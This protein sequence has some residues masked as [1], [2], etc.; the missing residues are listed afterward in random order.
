MVERLT[1]F[2]QE[3]V[4]VLLCFD[5]E[6]SKVIRN[7]VELDLFEGLYKEVATRVYVYI[8][9]F[10]K[11]PGEHISDLFDD[12]INGD[13]RRQ[14]DAYKNFLI[15]LFKSHESIDPHFVMSRL[16]TFVRQQQQ[17]AGIMRAADALQRGAPDADVQVDE[18]FRN[19]LRDRTDLFDAG[20]FL[21]DSRRSF[22]FLNLPDQTLPTGVPELDSRGAGPVKKGLHLFIA[23]TKRGKSWW[24]INLGKHALL[25]HLKVC[26]ITLELSEEQVAQRYFQSLFAMVK[27]GGEEVWNTVLDVDRK[28]RLVDLEQ[29]SHMPKLALDDSDIRSKLQA[30]VDQWGVRFN[31]VLIKEFPTGKLTTRN[32]EAYLDSL[33]AS[34][35]FVPDL[36]IVDYADMMYIDTK[37]YRADVGRVYKDLRGV[38]GERNLAL[39]TASQAHREGEKV[40]L[41]TG[42][43]VA[44]DYSKVGTS[45][46]TIT[47]SQTPDERDLGLARLHVAASRVDVDSYTVLISQSYRTGQFV[48]QSVLLDRLYW[49]LMEEVAEE[50][51]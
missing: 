7:T 13:D 39:A 47:Y 8:D 40:R 42:G 44:E 11:A 5:E 28:G 15:K 10:S 37:N 26:H 3:N 50:G 12:I 38:A 19:V 17:K 27:R 6:N 24:L 51:Q 30:K 34:H 25:R 29:I 46:T 22:R 16:S 20:A 18:I 31:R 1:T 33:E 41:L 14:S 2:M 43:N 9:G 48:L 32:L 45:D 21:A 35:G 49:K 36:L 23:L 4:V